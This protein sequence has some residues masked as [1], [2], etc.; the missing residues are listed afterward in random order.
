MDV[1][2][3][4]SICSAVSTSRSR[5][6]ARRSSSR[7]QRPSLCPTST[8]QQTDASKQTMLSTVDDTRTASWSA[9]FDNLLRDCAGLA[10]FSVSGPIASLFVHMCVLYS[11]PKVRKWTAVRLL[12][13][14]VGAHSGIN[15]CLHCVADASLLPAFNYDSVNYRQKCRMKLQQLLKPWQYTWSE[16]AVK[17]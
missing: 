8:D 9:S 4:S 12:S 5:H 17:V 7:R 13:P 16:L 2:S 3:P 6:A 11:A 10:T 14:F 15:S 1:G